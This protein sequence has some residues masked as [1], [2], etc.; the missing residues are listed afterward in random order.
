MPDGIR[1]QLYV[2]SGVYRYSDFATL[3]A[4]IISLISFCQN[5]YIPRKMFVSFVLFLLLVVLTQD[6]MFMLFGFLLFYVTLVQRGSILIIFF[7]L[8]LLL[9]PIYYLAGIES[10]EITG[11]IYNLSSIDLILEELLIRIVMP[12]LNGGYSLNLITFLFGE[13]FDF[14]FFIPWFE[15]RGQST[16]HNSVDSFYVTVF[17]KHGLLGLTLFLVAIFY[18]LRHQSKST[19]IWILVYFLTHNGLYQADFL[20]MMIF[21]VLYAKNKYA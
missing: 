4:Q 13:G 17:V 1:K 21:L 9:I 6:R 11:R 3:F 15:Y 19:L 5:R 8:F 10:S 16:S 14:K 7:S 2:R 20:I 12:V 18:P